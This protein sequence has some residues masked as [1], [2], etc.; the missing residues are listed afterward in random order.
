MISVLKSIYLVMNKGCK[1]TQCYNSKVIETLNLELVTTSDLL[2]EKFE[3]L[4][5][6]E[7]FPSPFQAV[8][9]FNNH[10]SFD[11]FCSPIKESF[12]IFLT[13]DLTII[14]ISIFDHWNLVGNNFSFF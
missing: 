6:F 10:Q 2:I 1:G 14:F 13:L 11:Q 4:C 9:G 5:P 8:P 3:T 7:N 12:M